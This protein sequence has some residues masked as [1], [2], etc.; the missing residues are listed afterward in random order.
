MTFAR[1]PVNLKNTNY[2]TL[3][4][5]IPSTGQPL[6]VVYRLCAPSTLS[7]SP[8]MNEAAGL[9]RN[10]TAADTCRSTHGLKLLKGSA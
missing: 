7:V 8:E 2:K 3:D 1:I 6:D 9:K 4:K 5:I 10:K